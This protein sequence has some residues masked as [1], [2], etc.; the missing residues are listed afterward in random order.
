MVPPAPKAKPA[1]TK[2][3]LMARGRAMFDSATGATIR[4]K[5][6]AA[7]R[8]LLKHSK[9]ITVTAKATFTPAGAAAVTAT[10]TFKLRR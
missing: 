2:A 1:R 7:G 6:T 9:R 4:L 10:R 5:L 8:R 3:V